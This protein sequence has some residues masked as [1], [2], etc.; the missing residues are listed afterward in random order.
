MTVCK[1]YPKS[2]PQVLYFW[3]YVSSQIL[4]LINLPCAHALWK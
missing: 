3:K 2:M 1:D 4:L